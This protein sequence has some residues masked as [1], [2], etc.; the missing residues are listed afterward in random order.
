M[1]INIIILAYLSI[2]FSNCS[3]RVLTRIEE[4]N[5]LILS[6]VNFPPVD[7]PRNSNLKYFPDGSY[8][9]SYFRDFNKRL[10]DG[11]YNKYY[12]YD[13][14][15]GL[16]GKNAKREIF[17]ALTFLDHKRVVFH[18]NYNRNVSP[19]SVD[20]YYGLDLEDSSYYNSNIK[21]S[22]T[23]IGYYIL[24]H[25]KK[26]VKVFLFKPY[27][28]NNVLKINFVIS[29]NKSLISDSIISY[30]FKKKSYEINDKIKEQDW[31]SL[32]YYDK[33]ELK[34]EG[35]DFVYTYNIKSNTCRNNLD[36]EILSISN[37]S[38]ITKSILKLKEVKGDLNRGCNNCNKCKRKS[39]NHLRNGCNDCYY[40]TYCEICRKCNIKNSED[41]SKGKKNPKNRKRIT[42]YR[43]N[44][45]VNQKINS[46]WK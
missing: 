34:K 24:G 19:K 7:S 21:N 33:N 27:D 9:V 17:G 40:C 42:S 1:K 15:E 2:F 31:F 3:K 26:N 30:D 6:E 12:G 46:N 13:L 14:A 28:R 16:G 25:D 29:D 43:E 18:S 23:L 37:D 44:F 35:I 20:L 5:S 36:F 22:F 45:C 10:I 11:Y 32:K 38:V 8:I 41:C 4:C 39:Y